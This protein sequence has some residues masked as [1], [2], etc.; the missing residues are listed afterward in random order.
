MRFM[1]TIARKIPKEELKESQ[2]AKEDQRKEKEQ[3]SKQ[4]A[5]DAVIDLTEDNFQKEVVDTKEAC[6]VYYTT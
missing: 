3:S 1:R 6:L 4:K 2:Q 5:Y